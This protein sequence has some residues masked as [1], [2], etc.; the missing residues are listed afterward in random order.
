[1]LAAIAPEG[2]AQ[3][4]SALPEAYVLGHVTEQPGLRLNG[5]PFS[6]AGFDHFS[7]QE[8]DE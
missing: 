8:G 7:T 5:R 1:L 4:L 3:V 2:L 6:K